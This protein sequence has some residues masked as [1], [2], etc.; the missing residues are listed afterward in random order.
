MCYFG[1]FD[2]KVYAVDAADGRVRWTFETGGAILSSPAV[3]DGL[4]AIGSQDGVI[5]GLEADSGAERFRF[6]TGKTVWCSPAI[7]AGLVICG[8]DDGNVYAL[9]TSTGA[10]RWR[11]VTGGA[12]FSSPAVSVEDGTLYIGSDD[13]HVYAL[14]VDTGRERWHTDLR[15]RVLG[16]PAIVG[17]LLYVGGEGSGGDQPGAMFALEREHGAILWRFETGAT[18]W[19]SP[20]ARGD[21]LWFG[22][23]DGLLR[24]LRATE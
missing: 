3:A 24:R 16:S 22:A 20:M 4:L 9:D 21:S 11:F 12:V 19:S 23:H 15:G 1:A 5:Y 17:D 7:H 13:H 8:S 14:H 10:E 18:T 6:Q 2:H